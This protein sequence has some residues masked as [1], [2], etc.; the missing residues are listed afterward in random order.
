[1][2]K[3]PV[4]LELRNKQAVL[5]GAGAVAVRKAKSLAAAQKYQAA[6]QIALSVVQRDKQVWR[7]PARQL[8]VDIFHV[9]PDDSDLASEY[10]RQ[11]SMALY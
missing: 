7:E 2:P 6:L 4:Y 10:R 8:M 1:M 5:V 9:L 3:Y 11:L